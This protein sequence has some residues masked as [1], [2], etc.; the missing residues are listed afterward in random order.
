[1]TRFETFDLRFFVCT[2]SIYLQEEALIV[3]L[4]NVEFFNLS[5]KIDSLVSILLTLDLDYLYTLY[6]H[7]Y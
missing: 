3:K 6:L 7:C 5:K 2:I 4:C 1:M